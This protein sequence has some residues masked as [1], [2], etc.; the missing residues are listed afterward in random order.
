M[1]NE[2]FSEI[3]QK[4]L[5]ELKTSTILPASLTLQTNPSIKL[6]KDFKIEVVFHNK[7][8]KKML[9][10]IAECPKEIGWHG[11]VEKIDDKRYEI[12]DILVFPQVVTGA[13]VNP[14]ET[15]YTQWIIDTATN[16]P[17][18]FNK[19]RFH[20]HSHVEM[21]TSPSGVDT[22][23][24]QTLLQNIPDFYIFGI[25]NKRGSWWMNI[26]DIQNN[27]LYEKEDIEYKYIP[28]EEEDWATDM[29]KKYVKEPPKTT[30][31]PTVYGGGINSDDYVMKDGIKVYKRWAKDRHWDSSFN[32][33]VESKNS[34]TRV[35]DDYDDYYGENYWRKRYEGYGGV[36]YD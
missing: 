3:L 22:Q 20:G 33:Y 9:S 2:L 35:E 17:D 10:L 27:V 16:N 36:N 24:Q 21:A 23:Y 6:P 26:M 14:D 31:A 8:Y 15:E 30:T 5:E 18:D 7:A 25:F 32:G 12:T 29:I 28:D 13:T 19:M 4:K 1:T 11:V 34:I